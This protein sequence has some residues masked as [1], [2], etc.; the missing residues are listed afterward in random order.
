[1]E[2]LF[3][4]LSSGYLMTKEGSNEA[5]NNRKNILRNYLYNLFYSNIEQ[6]PSDDEDQDTKDTTYRRAETFTNGTLHKDDKI[7]PLRRATEETT[8]EK[9]IRLEKVVKGDKL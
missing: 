4:K 3:K 7:Q 8:I 6:L 9:E 5:H 1:M 2:G